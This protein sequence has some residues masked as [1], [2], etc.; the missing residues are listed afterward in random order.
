MRRALRE[1]A[2]NK[3]R[4]SEAPPEVRTILSWIGRNSLPVSAREDTKHVD[5][6]LHALDIRLDGDPS[7]ASSVR[8]ERRILNVAIRYAIRQKVLTIN[9]LPKGKEE[10]AA[11][12]VAEAVDKRSLLN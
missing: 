9:L 1:Y 7:A 2:F 4:R 12:K 5:A 11:P 3:L 10:G 6:V 8:R